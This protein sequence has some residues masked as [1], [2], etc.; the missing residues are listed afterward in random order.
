[1]N[2]IEFG[3]QG[4]ALAASFL[5]AEGFSIVARNYRWKKEEIDLIAITGGNLVFVEV[6][7]RKHDTYA[8]PEKSVSPSKQSHLIKAANAFIQEKQLN[9]DARF[10]IISIIHN[11]YE[12]RIN[13][14]QNAFYPTL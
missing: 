6:K 9:L 7:T 5:V 10:D 11:Q 4:E 3:Q 13:H 2:H 12:T 14:I 1:M 8:P